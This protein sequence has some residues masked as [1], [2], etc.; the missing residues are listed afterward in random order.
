MN[1]NTKLRQ[2]SPRT[3]Q[4]DKV[5]VKAHQKIKKRT[6]SQK[7]LEA[8]EVVAQLV[9][10]GEGREVIQIC[11]DEL[12]LSISQYRLDQYLR[13]VRA[14]LNPKT[15]SNTGT[16]NTGATNNISSDEEGRSSTNQSHLQSGTQNR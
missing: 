15:S 11:L 6:K 4:L 13:E 10:R 5:V 3:K 12:G 2:S 14:K 7:L 8:K 16:K 1:T 9:M